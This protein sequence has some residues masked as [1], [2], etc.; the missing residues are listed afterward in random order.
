MTVS[1]P[2]EP[3]T[4]P[5]VGPAFYDGWAGDTLVSRV[6]GFLAGT[7]VRTA[8]GPMPIERVAVGDQMWLCDGD[9]TVVLW[10]AQRGIDATSLARQPWLR[11]VR[12]GAGALGPGRPG[13]DL[14]V[15]PDQMIAGGGGVASAAG[16]VNGDRIARLPGEGGVTYFRLGLAAKG[17]LDVH[18]L[19]CP[20]DRPPSNPA[21]IVRMRRVVDA[22]LDVHRLESRIERVTPGMVVGWAYDPDRPESP[23]P[24]EVALDDVPIAWGMADIKRPDLEMLGLGAG[25]CAFALR[26]DAPDGAGRPRMLSVRRATD[27]SHLAGSPALL[28]SPDPG[29]LPATAAIAGFAAA[30]G[31]DRARRRAAATLFET[32]DGLVGRANLSPAAAGTECI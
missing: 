15:A 12:I 3:A 4:R 18:G 19:A 10:T 9:L 28:L 1:F 24:L 5:T 29:E 25:A 2:T 30:A 21:A 27:G 23:V 17:G 6:D 8:A 14:D 31:D 13:A 16:L 7:I 32:L 26:F 22:G 11:P 20:F